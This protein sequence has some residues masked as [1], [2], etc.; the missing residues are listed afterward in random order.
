M[1]TAMS[2]TFKPEVLELTS[3]QEWRDAFPA[4]QALRPKMSLETFLNNRSSCLAGGYRLFGLREKD[5]V[6]AVAGVILR[7]HLEFGKQLEVEDFAT[8]KDYQQRGFGLSL[9]KWIIEF[10]TQNGCYRVKLVSGLSR[11]AAHALYEKAGLEK[12]GYRFQIKFSADKA[13]Y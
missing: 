10:A 7:P 6:V 3:E 11:M 2:P 4:I 12:D 1:Q 13:S 9:M 8:R 5:A